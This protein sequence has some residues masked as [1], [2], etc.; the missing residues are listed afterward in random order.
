MKA[1]PR[2]PN[3]TSSRKDPGKFQANLQRRLL[4]KWESWHAQKLIWKTPG[5]TLFITKHSSYFPFLLLC[6]VELPAHVCMCILSIISRLIC[7]SPV[8]L[9]IC[10]NHFLSVA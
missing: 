10:W 5:A 4:A 2:P 9:H 8:V 7:V 3:G 1:S 6:L